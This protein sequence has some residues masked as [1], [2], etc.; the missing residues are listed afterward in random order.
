MGI[1][2]HM[3]L[4]RAGECVRESVQ[5]NG[6]AVRGVVNDLMYTPAC[7]LP[8]SLQDNGAGMPHKDI[9]DMLGRVL[10]GTKYGVKQVRICLW[11][12]IMPCPS[13]VILTIYPWHSHHCCAHG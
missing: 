8:L 4:R 7:L 1:T 11:H 10:S 12:S 5:D 3:W 6:A 2:R 9:P 13:S